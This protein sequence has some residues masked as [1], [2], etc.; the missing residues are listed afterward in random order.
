MLCCTDPGDV[1]RLQWQ[2]QSRDKEQQ[3]SRVSSESSQLQ[4]RLN[5]AHAELRQKSTIIQQKDAVIRQKDLELQHK[6]D[7]IQQKEVTIH[8]KDAVIQQKVIAISQKDAL[9]RQN[10]S[11]LQQRA[12]IDQE[13]WS[14]V[15]QKEVA[16]R[17]KDAV[18]QQK[19]VAIRQKDAVIQQK[20]VA[21]R[22]KDAVIDQKEITIR[23]KDAVI[24]QKVIVIQQKDAQIQGLQGELQTARSQQRPQVATQEIAFWQVSRREV[25]IKE[26]RVLGRGAWGVV[27]EGS[28]RGQRVAVKCVYPDILLPQTR[29]R[30]RREIGTMAQVRHP[31]LV[32][33]MA[34]VLE[35]PSGP[36]IITEIMDT[37]L[38]SAYE[39]QR[40]GDCQLRVFRDVAAAMNY[41]HCQREPILH[42]DLS[43]ANVLLEAM[44]VGVWRAKVSD[45]GSANLVRL[46]TT[47][48]EGAIVY[49][50]PEAFPRPPGVPTH[51]PAQTPKIDV[52]SYGVLVCEVV[53]ARFPDPDHF[54]AMVGE[55]RGVRPALHGLVTRCIKWSPT[56]RPSMADIL[57]N[58][59]MMNQ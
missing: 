41:L 35:D 59:D 15:H 18:I 48:G 46:A 55:M 13:L 43:T 5:T 31:N 26:D 39:T 28:F 49:T 8:Q 58:L 24:Q 2:R 27:C 38:R 30:I 10:D 1:E 52:Y 9:I 11:E 3:F 12:T 45:F 34:A 37:S 40:L 53:L 47:L 51:A 17:Q 22:Q 25:V 7:T 33:F 32:L 16:I 29:E 23:Q 14:Q 57:T 19:E 4:Q 54:R 42:R 6:A 20:E 21:I 50:A 44:G 56:E 36:K